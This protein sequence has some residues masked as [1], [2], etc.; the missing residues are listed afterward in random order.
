[1]AYVFEGTYEDAGEDARYRAKILNLNVKSREGLLQ[2]A[3]DIVEDA[4]AHERLDEMM[5]VEVNQAY[6][7]MEDE[8]RKT[9]AF[10]MHLSKQNGEMVVDVI[11]VPA[12]NWRD[13]LAVAKR[14]KMTDYDSSVTR[15]WVNPDLN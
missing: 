9:G 15:N 12:S 6:C 10:A 5:A 3:R 14:I 1:M 11:F 2:A 13:A 8:S 4:L 7:W